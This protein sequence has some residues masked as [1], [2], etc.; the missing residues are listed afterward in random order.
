M[1][2][3]TKTIVIGVLVL[4]TA[5]PAFAGG[6]RETVTPDVVTIQWWTHQR[7][8]LHYVEEML[9]V[10]NER[11][12]D[13]NVVLTSYTTG[14]DE[15]LDL[16]FEAGTTPDTV[17]ILPDAPAYVEMGRVLAIEDYLPADFI[18]KFEGYRMP[19]VN[20]WDGKFYTLPNVGH[21]FRFVYNAEFFEAAGLD[22]D[23]PPRSF[24]EVIEYAETLDEHG[25]TYSPRKHAFMLPIVETWI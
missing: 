24:D 14:L 2:K 13:I 11:N 23:R 10:F 3:L 22:P 17:S 8:D 19:N 4:F 5:L 15:A 1:S 20:N 9:E 7:H 12:E 18:A 6:E 16:S 25:R 21:N